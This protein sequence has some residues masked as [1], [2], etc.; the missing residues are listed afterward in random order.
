MAVGNFLGYS[1]PGCKTC[2]SNKASTA[3]QVQAEQCSTEGAWKSNGFD[4]AVGRRCELTICKTEVKCFTATQSV[5][6]LQNMPNPGSLQHSLEGT[7]A[8]PTHAACSNRLPFSTPVG[9]G[10]LIS[11]RPRIMQIYEYPTENMLKLLWI[12]TMCMVLVGA[13]RSL[14]VLPLGPLFRYLFK[15]HGATAD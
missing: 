9:P 15:E 4:A 2:H 11:P 7:L 13:G 8:V 3:E 1:N 12:G 14:F 10:N 6:H 5:K